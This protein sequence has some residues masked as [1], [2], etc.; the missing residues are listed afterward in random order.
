MTNVKAR[1]LI[2]TYRFPIYE[3]LKVF[4]KELLSTPDN[5]GKG[6]LFSNIPVGNHN[7]TDG[8]WFWYSELKKLKAAKIISDT[9]QIKQLRKT[10]ASYL[11]NEL[12]VDPF[13]VQKLLDHSD[14]K[15]SDEHYIELSLETVRSVLD[16]A[17][18]LVSD[19]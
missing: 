10:F 7:Y 9:Y 5:E 4:L 15:I 3:E 14:V 16:K 17:R 12:K 6:R 18:F 2:K 11:V 1:K 19:E 13:I 8:I